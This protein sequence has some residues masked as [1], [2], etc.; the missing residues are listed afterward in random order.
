MSAEELKTAF[1]E[2][3]DGEGLVRLYAALCAEGIDDQVA[4]ILDKVR[5]IQ[6]RVTLVQAD[7]SRE[8]LEALCR[9]PHPHVR[10][11][12]AAHAHVSEEVCLRLCEDQQAPVR[13]ALR[14]NPRCHRVIKGALV[15]RERNDHTWEHL[16]EAVW[17]ARRAGLDEDALTALVADWTQVDP[18][19]FAALT[20]EQVSLVM[21]VLRAKLG[22]GPMPR[23]PRK[24]RK[25]KR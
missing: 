8:L 19:D 1:L 10:Q 18:D 24:S 12:V 3:P 13:M 5:P 15:Q 6:H 4:P 2:A 23:K 16:V 14:K 9:D 25:R 22:H 21:E 17:H 7:A 20:G 11:V